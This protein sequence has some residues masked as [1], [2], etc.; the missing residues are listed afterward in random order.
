M[1]V[2]RGNDNGN[3]LGGSTAAD[4]ILG[5]DGNDLLS[6][7]GGND[8][9][10]GGNGADVLEGGDGND[11]LYGDAGDDDLFGGNGSDRLFAGRAD[12]RDFLFGGRQSDTLVASDGFDFLDGG[13]GDDLLIGVAAGSSWTT[14]IG[15]SFGRSGVTVNLQDGF[16]IDE[17]GTRDTLR[18][19]R[20]VDGTDRRDLIFG[21]ASGNFITAYQGADRIFGGDGR[22]ELNYD[23]GGNRGIFADLSRGFVNDNYGFQDRVSSIEMI[24]ATGLA[25]RLIGSAADETFRPF[26]GND[27]IVG[28]GGFDEVWYDLDLERGGFRGVEVD[29]ADGFAIDASGDLDS[30]VGIE[31]VRGSLL[32]DRLT[33]DS[34]ANRLDGASG[35]DRL[36]GAGGNDTLAGGEGF[37]TLFGGAGR[38]LASFSGDAE[39]GGTLGVLVRLEQAFAIDGFGSLDRLNALESVRG[40]AFDDR[41]FGSSLAND[42]FGGGGRDD[43]RGAAG[44]DTFEGGAGTDRLFGGAGTDRFLFRDGFEIDRVEDF[45]AAAERLDFSAHEKILNFDDLR[46]RQ[47]GAHTRI[48]AGGDTLFLIGVAADDITDTVFFF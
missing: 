46:L 40:T 8:A 36:I 29:L 6:G 41:I 35:N 31:G 48:D 47:V 25:D 12:G 26:A 24:R 7:R 33:G 2:I 20:D 22:D 37:D 21:D 42:L 23:T 28:G 44:N 1:A 16:A 13:Q 14:T 17:F 15:F 32:N 11:R 27:D 38:D 43:L 10:F 5:L 3:A 19:I 4:R 9:L 30:L 39:A 34:Q 18:N 45:N